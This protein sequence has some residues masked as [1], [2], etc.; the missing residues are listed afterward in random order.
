MPL[1]TT[2]E[3]NDQT[4]W[5]AKQRN[6]LRRLIKSGAT[7]AYVCTDQHGRPSNGGPVNRWWQVR[8]GLVQEIAGPLVLCG[9]GALHGTFKPHR[10]AGNR[11]WVAGFVGEV[12]YHGDDKL[13]SL[14]REIVGEVLPD[15]AMSDSVGVRT[16]RKDLTGANLT[17]AYLTGANL[18]G[19]YLTRANLT[20]AD[21]TDADLTDADL[22]GADLTGADL[23]RAN[24]TRAYY[25]YGDLPDTWERDGG[26][27]LRR[28]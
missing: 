12:K 23:T 6:H 20:D 14:R 21:L 13:G 28:K 5:T 18:T 25:P 1:M 8:P 11:V 17:R 27:Y 10:W 16:G 4:G 22:T 24:L 2:A 15:C 7:I 19:A 3:M 26:G 9:P